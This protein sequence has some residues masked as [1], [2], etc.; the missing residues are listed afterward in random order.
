MLRLVLSLITIPKQQLGIK[1]FNL[2]N[3]P[4]YFSDDMINIE[5]LGP[6]LLDIDKI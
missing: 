1:Q 2:E 4:D 6:N 3:C 5:N